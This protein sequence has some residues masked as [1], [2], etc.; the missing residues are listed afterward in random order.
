[1]TCVPPHADV[2]R[3]VSRERC[4]RGVGRGDR[5]GDREK[6]R[7]KSH[8]RRPSR[9]AAARAARGLHQTTVLIKCGRVPA[10]SPLC[11]PPPRRGAL[12]LSRSDACQ[13]A[14]A[15]GVETRRWPW[16][17]GVHLRER[18]IRPGTA[19][20]APREWRSG[21]APAFPAPAKEDGALREVRHGGR[22]GRGAAE[23]IPVAPCARCS[24]DTR[25]MAAQVALRRN[26]T[27]VPP[28]HE[29]LRALTAPP[30]AGSH[31]EPR[32]HPADA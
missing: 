11:Q 7:D 2:Q 20:C 24:S 30:P 1:M 4:A 10:S 22:R 31:A 16:H 19:P 32:H 8:R 21:G 26:S 28:Q 12:R 15:S 5:V 29:A 18:R 13:L 23:A 27:R 25:E 3:R 17:R 14:A 9:S 6:E